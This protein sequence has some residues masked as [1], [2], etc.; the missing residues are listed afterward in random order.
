MISI[1]ERANDYHRQ[2]K[3]FNKASSYLINRGFTQE[4]TLNNMIDN[5]Y[6]GISI[7]DK[8]DYYYGY[9]IFPI[10]DGDGEIISFTGRSFLDDIK[11]THKHWKGTINYFYN[12]KKLKEYYSVVITESPLDTLSLNYSGFYSIATMGSSRLPTLYTDLKNKNITILFDTDLN[13]TGQSKA[14]LL[15]AKLYNICDN[16]S[17]GHIDLPNGLK[18]IDINDLLKQDKSLD[19]TNFK[20]QILDII[21]KAKKYIYI[22]PIKTPYVSNHDFSEYNIVDIISEHVSLKQIG[23]LYRGYCSFHNDSD[24]SFTVYPDT[25]SFFCFGCEKGGDVINFLQEIMGFEFKEA[26][27]YLEIN[28]G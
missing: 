22:E 1:E 27:E 28:Y 26:K 16:V 8:T 18:K 7:Q 13:N 6:L 19:K 21:Y 4:K 25:S 23:N 14:K 3:A 2:F 24:P 5:N 10:I 15:A 20:Q 11:P 12:H 17:I 9:L